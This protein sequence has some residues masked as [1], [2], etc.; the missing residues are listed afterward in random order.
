[1]RGLDISESTDLSRMFRLCKNLS[2]LLIT[3]DTSNITNMSDMFGECYKLEE[4]DL[5]TFNTLHVTDMSN[6]F[7]RCY[8][9][10]T[11]KYEFDTTNVKNMQRMFYL[12][13]R[14]PI[15]DSNAVNTFEMY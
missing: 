13:H 10:K 1:M 6:M 12:S 11:L 2:T 5:S 14:F 9:L 8:N 15:D 7:R 3:A 4:L